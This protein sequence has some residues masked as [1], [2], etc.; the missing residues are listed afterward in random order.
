MPNYRANLWK[1]K[2]IRMLF[3]MHF[4]G[5]VLVPFFTQW[6]GLKLSQVLFLNAWFM[7]WN[8][9]LEVPTGA[10]AD[11]IG[12]KNCLVLGSLFGVLAVQLYLYKPGF[13]GFMVAEV[14]FAIAFTLHSGA[15]EALAYDSLVAAGAASDSKRVLARLESWKLA[16]ILV[17]VISG[18][19]IA[20]RWGLAAP[21]RAYTWPL[22]M[23]ILVA[24]SLR[25]PP[26]QASSEKK[27][28][29][30]S[31]LQE[32]TRFFLQNR[33]LVLL[34]ADL[35]FTNA[36]ACVIIW[37][38]Q[39][40]LQ[41]AGLP[42]KYFGFVQAASCL[43]QIALLN[44]VHWLEAR[45]GSKRRLLLLGTLGTGLAFVGLGLV[46]DYLPWVIGGIVIAEA[47]GL[48]RPPIFSSY[49]NKYIPSDRRATVLS[50]VSMLRT[51]ALV[52]VNV[53]TGLL[54]DWS[55]T[56]T[57]IILGALL[58]AAAAFSSV[59]ERHLHE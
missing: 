25:E 12:R 57:M 18:G 46:P 21:L 42:V 30:L 43:G 1:L 56:R 49:M 26:R 35:V 34:T 48:S 19:F 22:L 15:D 36:L 28:P 47:F 52:I 16:G 4:F 50:V 44:N 13:T 27:L 3:W 39:P 17:A 38:C 5:A 8:F 41:H 32:G 40:L 9:A 55:L 45:L 51:F 37:F 33:T 2:A 58:V 23:S 54:A 53:V 29:Y 14:A 11:S 20:S 6:G 59:E 7:L 31:L 10:L 24:L